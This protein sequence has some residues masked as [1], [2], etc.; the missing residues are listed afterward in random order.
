MG[1]SSAVAGIIGL[2]LLIFAIIDYFIASGFHLFVAINLVAGVFA[3]ILWATTSSRES[4]GTVL[5]SRTTQLRRQRVGLLVG[6]H[7]SGGR[8]QLPG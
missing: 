7:R 3:L 1:K 4:L 5:G 2:V 8:D 6:V